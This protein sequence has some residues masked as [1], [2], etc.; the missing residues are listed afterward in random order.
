MVKGIRP[1]REMAES[2]LAQ[3]RRGSVRGPFQI[4]VQPGNIW[5]VKALNREYYGDEFGE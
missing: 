4:R 3:D 5:R 2:S 1:G